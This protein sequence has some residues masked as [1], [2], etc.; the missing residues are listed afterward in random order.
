MAHHVTISFAE[1]S[2]RSDMQVNE[3]EVLLGL[4]YKIITENTHNV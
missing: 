1:E 3:A 2:L 4:I